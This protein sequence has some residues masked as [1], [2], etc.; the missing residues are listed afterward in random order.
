MARMKKA[1]AA[2]CILTSCLCGLLAHPTLAQSAMD[3]VRT[4]S[5]NR[6]DD[7]L[8]LKAWVPVNSHDASVQLTREQLWEGLAMRARAPGTFVPMLKACDIL[9]DGPIAIVRTC[10]YRGMRFEDLVTLFPMKRIR[11][12]SLEHPENHSVVENLIEG[13]SNDSLVLRFRLVLRGGNQQQ[14]QKFSDGF[15]EV[16]EGEFAAAVTRTLARIRELA[17]AGELASSSKSTLLKGRIFHLSARTSSM[18]PASQS[19][20]CRR[21]HSR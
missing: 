3:A 20:W 2:I 21:R 1:G 10:T 14:A 7:A 19:A 17:L 6:S 13:H 11:F 12:Q 8:I 18:L 16:A 9:Q 5:T 4:T 15:A